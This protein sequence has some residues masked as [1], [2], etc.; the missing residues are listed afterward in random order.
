[1]A[2]TIRDVAKKAGVSVSTASLA[3]NG[4]PLVSPETR[5][6]V[7]EA[8]RVLNYYPHTTAKNLADGR[9]RTLSLIIP[10]TLEHLF[11]SAGF[12]GRLLHGMHRAATEQGYR[13]S[14]HIVESEAEA[15][16]QIYT[17]VRTRSA[18]GLL[19]TNPTVN[20]PY[21]EALRQH[22]VPF[23]FV[24]RP[25]ET[26]LSYVDNDN[27][28]VGHLGTGHLIA[29]GHRR[30]AFLNGPNRFTFC[31][32]RLEGYRRALAEAGLPYDEGLV[33]TSELT[34]EDAY[35]AIRA[36]LGR[37]CRFT[38]LF[39]ASDIQAIGALRA[40]REQECRVPEDAAL[41]CVN[42]TMLTRH[43]IP[44]LTTVDLNEDQLGYWAVRL[45]IR[46]IQTGRVESQLVPS[47]LVVRRSCSYDHPCHPDFI[48]TEEGR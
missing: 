25:L 16:E 14:L 46:Q 42:D 20:P 3:L 27:V 4:K 41:V 19:I 9:T 26:D 33:W 23:V 13:L 18:D 8:A 15:A 43:F 1:M 48:P 34:E 10:V 28:E 38:A 7:L 24:G 29:A 12:F 44:P 39:A 22:T 21:L 45:L 2:A 37:G 31:L 36:A 40:L 35:R 6:K 47:R 11:S 32:D 30:I 17:I 5:R